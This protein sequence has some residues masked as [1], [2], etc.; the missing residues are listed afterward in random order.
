MLAAEKEFREL[1]E[2]A[3]DLTGG[4]FAGEGR[5]AVAPDFNIE[6]GH[7]NQEPRG[8]AADPRRSAMGLR[9]PNAR[10]GFSP[11]A[12]QIPGGKATTHFHVFYAST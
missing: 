6:P 9:R 4:G 11:C 1:P 7:T 5:L 10:P 3:L 8:I 12:S 2:I